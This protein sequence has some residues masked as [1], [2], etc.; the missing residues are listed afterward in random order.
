MPPPPKKIYPKNT[1]I[2]WYL[3]VW[4]DTTGKT[5]FENQQ[6]M[7]LFVRVLS[8]GVICHPHVLLNNSDI[9]LL[10]SQRKI[11]FMHFTSCYCSLWFFCFG[12]CYVPYVIWTEPHSPPPTKKT[13]PIS[14]KKRVSSAYAPASEFHVTMFGLKN[15]FDVTRFLREG[16]RNEYRG[17]RCRFHQLGYV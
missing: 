2:V 8:S 17:K 6:G 4:K 14:K 11:H 16:R 3:G 1:L 5:F 10:I 15:T 7:K 12:K 13:T 9:F